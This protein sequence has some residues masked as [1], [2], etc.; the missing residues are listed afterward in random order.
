MR[1]NAYNGHYRQGTCFLGAVLGDVW[2]VFLR[3]SE[4]LCALTYARDTEELD[5][6]QP[7]RYIIAMT[8]FVYYS[9]TY[10][11]RLVPV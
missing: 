8:D 6:L 7:G 5:I 9:N 10:S 2:A 11:H 4:F 1:G 3:A